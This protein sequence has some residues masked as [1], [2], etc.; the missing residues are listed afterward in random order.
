MLCG[1]YRYGL[2]RLGFQ[3]TCECSKEEAMT[4]AARTEQVSAG[5]VLF[6]AFELGNSR[7]KVGST[8]GLGQKPR[9]KTV[10]AGD[11]A[12]VLEEIER[13]RKRFG[14]G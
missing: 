3:E 8:I 12:G 9:E 5:E 2:L 11:V 6:V 7:W 4:T 1:G 14:G 10:Q 13:A